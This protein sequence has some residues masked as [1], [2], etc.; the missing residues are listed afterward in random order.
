M[1]KKKAISLLALALESEP[2]VAFLVPSMPKR[3]LIESGRFS[4]A[5]IE[6]V[7]L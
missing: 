7:G 2:W 5:V 4:L 6:L 3:A 1:S